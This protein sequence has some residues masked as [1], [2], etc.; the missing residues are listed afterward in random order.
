MNTPGDRTPSEGSSLDIPST[1]DEAEP[2][3]AVPTP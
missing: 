3:R 1:T 2:T